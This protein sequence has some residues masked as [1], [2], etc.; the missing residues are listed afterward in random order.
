MVFLSV[1]AIGAAYGSAFLP[2]G[3]PGWAPWAMAVGASVLPVA[4]MVLGAV[5]RGR[6]GRLWIPFAFVLA[7]L[8][9]GFGAALAL[10]PDTAGADLWLGLPPRAAIVLYGVGLLPLLAVPLAY[11]LTFD[12]LHLSEADLARVAAAKARRR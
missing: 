10:P 9:G 2:G 4:T 3:A 1:L 7:V 6:I 12:D 8:V 11:A 5:R